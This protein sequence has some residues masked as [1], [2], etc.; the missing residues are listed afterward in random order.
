MASKRIFRACKLQGLSLHAD[1]LQRL[2]QE[3]TNEPSLE[4]DDVIYAI[5]NSIDKSK[6]TTSVV[7]LEAL[8]SALDTLL[9]VS[10]E[11]Q[12]DAIQVFNAFETPKLHYSS[13]TSSYELK[14]DAHR[15]IH[16]SP[17]YRINLL[18]D[19]FIS[20]DLRV[21]RNKMFAPPAVAVSNA[22]EYIE[23]SRI[24]SLLGVTGMKRVIGMIG[25]DERK[26]V[27]LEDL[28]SRIYVDLTN[29]TY[30][31]G[32]F[33]INCVVLVEGEVIDDVLH[34]HSM[35]FPPPEPKAQ[36]LE[37]LSG[38][39][40]LGVE[41]SAQQLEQI[42][43]LEAGDHHA[44]FIV[45]SDVHLDDPQVMKHLDVLFQGLEAVMPSLFILMGDFMS[46]SI[47]GGAGSNS[48]QDL[49]E[50][51]DELANLIL[52]YPR[53][54]EFSKF[55]L[56][57][58]PND[59]GSSKAFPRHP[60]RNQGTV[61]IR[62]YT[63]DIVI[64]RDDLHQKMQR[65]ALLPVLP[66]QD[67]DDAIDVDDEDDGSRRTSTHV[68]VSKHLFPL[69]DVDRE[70]D[71]RT[72]DIKW[73]SVQRVATRNQH[74]IFVREFEV[75]SLYT[76]EAAPQWLRRAQPFDRRR[77]ARHSIKSMQLDVGDVLE[78]DGA[79][80]DSA[81]NA[82]HEAVH[83]GY[84]PE[85]AMREHVVKRV[86]PQSASATW[87]SA[88]RDATFDWDTTRRIRPQSAKVQR[89]VNDSADDRK[90]LLASM[91][92]Q[93]MKDSKWT[94]M[95]FRSP[96]FQ[97][98]NLIKLEQ[99]TYQLLQSIFK[100]ERAKSQQISPKPRK[101]SANTRGGV[102][103]PTKA[104][105]AKQI[106]KKK[107][108][109]SALPCRSGL[110]M[111]GNRKLVHQDICSTKGD[112]T[113]QREE[114][115]PPRSTSGHNDRSFGRRKAHERN[116]RPMRSL[117]QM[118]SQHSTRKQI[119]G[120]VESTAA[121]NPATSN[122]T[123]LG[124]GSIRRDRIGLL[125]LGLFLGF[126][127]SKAK[128]KHWRPSQEKPARPTKSAEKQST[129]LSTTNIKKE[130]H[131][132]SNQTSQNASCPGNSLV[133]RP[134][135]DQ[136]LLED[137]AFHRELLLL[138]LETMPSQALLD[139][140]IESSH[141]RTHR[142]DLN[143]EHL[144]AGKG[145][146]ESEHESMSGGGDDP[147][148][149][150]ELDAVE[151]P[152]ADDPTDSGASAEIELVHAYSKVLDG[153]VLELEIVRTAHRN[154]SI[155]NS[156]PGLA[157]EL[158]DDEDAAVDVESKEQLAETSHDPP[159]KQSND[160]GLERIDLCKPPKP[161]T[162]VSSPQTEL[163]GYVEER[164]AQKMRLESTSDDLNYAHSSPGI[165]TSDSAVVNN[166][167]RAFKQNQ[168]IVKS[169]DAKRELSYDTSSHPCG[170]IEPPTTPDIADDVLQCDDK[171]G[172]MGNEYLAVEAM[173]DSCLTEENNQVCEE[174]TYSEIQAKQYRLQDERVQE[175][176]DVGECSLDSITKQAKQL[177]EGEQIVSAAHD[178]IFQVAVN[179]E[180]SDEVALG[181]QFERSATSNSHPSHNFPEV[182]QHMSNA[183]VLQ[184]DPE[185][186]SQVSSDHDVDVLL[187]GEIRRSDD[188]D[189]RDDEL[190]SCSEYDALPSAGKP[191]ETSEPDFGSLVVSEDFA[192]PS[193][194][195]CKISDP[196]DSAVYGA[197]ISDSNMRSGNSTDDG[198]SATESQEIRDNP[199]AQRPTEADLDRHPSK[200]LISTMSA[201][202]DTEDTTEV[203]TVCDVN[204]CSVATISF[205]NTVQDG[206]CEQLNM[207]ESPAN[208]PK[209]S[210]HKKHE[211]MTLQKNTLDK[212]SNGS[213]RDSD[214]H[215]ESRAFTR[216]STSSST[217]LSDE[218]TMTE[219]PSPVIDASAASSR[220]IHLN[221]ERGS[222]TEMNEADM[223]QSYS[224][225]NSADTMSEL[226]IGRDPVDSA[227]RI[228]TQLE[229]TPETDPLYPGV[230]L[231]STAAVPGFVSPQSES[232]SNLVSSQE[233]DRKRLV[234]SDDHETNLNTLAESS[235]TKDQETHGLDVH[236]EVT[237]RLVYIADDL[238]PRATTT[239]YADDERATG[240][241]TN[242]VS[243]T[244]H[245]SV[246]DGVTCQSVGSPYQRHNNQ[247]AERIQRQYRCF[248]QRQLITDQLKY[249]LSQHRRRS[250]KK[251]QRV[252]KNATQS[253][254][255][256]TLEE[257]LAP[258]CIAV[259][260]EVRGLGLVPGG[261]LDADRKATYAEDPEAQA[262]TTCGTLNEGFDKAGRDAFDRAKEG[263]K[264]FLLI[265]NSQYVY[266][267]S[268][269][270]AVLTTDLEEETHGNEETEE[271]GHQRQSIVH[272]NEETSSSHTDT[273][274][275]E[276]APEVLDGTGQLWESTAPVPSTSQTTENAAMV[277]SLEN[278]GQR[279]ASM[280]LA[281][282]D[283]ETL[284]MEENSLEN[285]IGDLQF[286]P[287][288]AEND[289]VLLRA[290]AASTALA[291]LAL[292]D[293]ED[294]GLAS[295]DYAVSADDAATE[296]LMLHRYGNATWMQRPTSHGVT[297]VNK[298]LAAD[299][300][301]PSLNQSASD[302]ARFEWQ[303]ARGQ[304]MLLESMGGWD[305]YLNAESA[306]TFYYHPGRDEYFTPV[307]ANNEADDV[308]AP[309]EFANAK[310]LLLEPHE[311]FETTYMSRE[312]D[313]PNGVY[314]SQSAELGDEWQVFIDDATQ[315]PFYCNSRT[316]ESA[317][318]RPAICQDNGQL[319]DSKTEYEEHGSDSST[320]WAMF[321]D[322]ASGAPYYVNLDTHETSWERPGDLD[323]LA[324][325]PQLSDRADH[326]GEDQEPAGYYQ[327]D[328][329]QNVHH[330]GDDQDEEDEYIIRID[331]QSA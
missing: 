9:A 266:D 155:G 215:V 163:G 229:A 279:H 271:L 225:R 112:T 289:E 184:V 3:L 284:E 306:T 169:C 21:K 268:V 281:F 121:D 234:A 159:V 168:E 185:C 132:D 92:P 87:P 237:E 275:D 94:E 224:E 61:R 227:E 304:S 154:V 309:W 75:E 7:S 241:S 256:A 74:Q 296:S 286:R 321:V 319:Q 109:E 88:S 53:L 201:D 10:S 165:N 136:S 180:L 145:A 161:V 77:E 80:R 308:G 4:L 290:R 58:G 73:Q 158:Q 217:Q 212:L 38:I 186:C 315:Q 60:V 6:M 218:S 102:E 274:S 188:I 291:A 32:L 239:P 261:L 228:E 91:M 176:E 90:E 202:V 44:T 310:A 220:A 208:V 250:R 103:R 235:R 166:A 311:H 179:Q 313:D 258:V 322:D 149:V 123:S 238:V 272:A 122:P 148:P 2:T 106:K 111:A 125:E 277:V 42:R 36:S 280:L 307:D 260:N 76:T 255:T 232:D 270:G 133:A 142:C 50:Y 79:R 282:D 263:E 292:D 178:H 72:P 312:E 100:K 84:S 301:A 157:P 297:V 97:Q 93:E 85:N 41:V 52:K 43:E 190:D 213:S 193:S 254:A 23:L 211:G 194:I 137:D 70:I 243:D 151:F 59:P 12:F 323:A 95:L 253:A 295:N 22:V 171:P 108:E 120:Q 153:S 197:T 244:T 219:E 205:N 1:A 130:E 40:P 101:A 129:R 28:T 170:R 264:P 54:A 134:L 135:L 198:E 98:T 55:V 96:G 287:Y 174:F 78:N 86:R 30:T 204:I 278:V 231:R 15:R 13:H 47:G 233:A 83:M 259:D 245:D 62:Y 177:S 16:A 318:E 99:E 329:Q 305:K 167:R 69:P 65:H 226:E 276:Q 57:P 303:H 191:Q 207:P 221:A 189:P 288:P 240:E 299:D 39:D 150:R 331:A 45:L 156:D 126:D 248:M 324:S 196:F 138:D 262:S 265:E 283:N 183:N 152:G 325:Q 35:G 327:Y 89:S 49:K 316:G 214:A 128:V 187:D 293:G 300:G 144:E 64:F 113:E 107:K 210:I 206:S 216:F 143:E 131:S 48:L 105:E 5:K 249:F 181:E 320:Q 8:E 124:E 117:N 29:A 242:L 294:A 139:S 330:H 302:D 146:L 164:G 182:Q 116:K 20:V 19:R 33:T 82:P 81:E 195:A 317:W 298:A 200:S 247:A 222:S 203:V 118:E 110:H 46:S 14:S 63:Q 328:D 175:A 114:T 230:A 18:R 199:L 140:N 252:S 17:E 173:G 24:E 71:E 269:I 273:H 160:G 257:A 236:L 26:R 246:V 251:P 127:A 192:E 209:T 31:N 267:E 66:D 11:N 27:Y 67:E 172:G 51:F 285:G 104:S 162:E 68:D 147:K 141:S 314:H 326:G 119:H 34:V 25:Q 223:S 37:V 56:V 115:K